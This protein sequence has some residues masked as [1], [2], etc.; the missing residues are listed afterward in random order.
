MTRVDEAADEEVFRQLAGRIS[1]VGAELDE[2]RGVLELLTGDL[3]TAD[4]LAG[5]VAGIARREADLADLVAEYHAKESLYRERVVSL[6]RLIGLRERVLEQL[7]GKTQVLDR[8]P[9]E[10]EDVMQTQVRLS[11][12]LLEAEADMHH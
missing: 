9:D 1:A 11:R 4:E 6:R 10:M 8:F 7:Q 3:F 2:C 12:Q 5:L